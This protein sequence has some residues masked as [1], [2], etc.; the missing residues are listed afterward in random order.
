MEKG[1]AINYKKPIQFG[2]G[3]NCCVDN[4]THVIVFDD[5]TRWAVCWRCANQ[6]T[7]PVFSL[8]IFNDEKFEMPQTCNCENSNCEHFKYGEIC[9]L[10][11]NSDNR[12]LFLGR[13]CL[14]CDESYPAEFK[15]AM[16]N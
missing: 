9:T 16:W 4:E 3:W 2:I 8:F 14:A 13:L 11:A 6:Y 7:G 12:A 5:G 15:V 1:I 10:T